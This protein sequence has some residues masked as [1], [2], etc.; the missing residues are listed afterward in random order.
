MKASTATARVGCSRTGR[1]R[2]RDRT[3]GGWRG[4]GA[5][6][7]SCRVWRRGGRQV[8]RPGLAV[9]AV[10]GTSRR[11]VGVANV[12]RSKWKGSGVGKEWS[13]RQTQRR[14]RRR[15][16]RVRRRGK[17]A[18]SRRSRLA[19]AAAI[20]WRRCRSGQ[21]SVD[22]CVLLSALHGLPL[23]VRREDVDRRCRRWPSSWSVP[24]AALARGLLLA[25][26]SFRTQ[27]P[28]RLHVITVQLL[29]AG[30]ASE[31]E[32]EMGSGNANNVCSRLGLF[33]S[34]VLWNHASVPC[35]TDH[36]MT[37]RSPRVSVC[38]CWRRPQVRRVVSAGLQSRS[39]ASCEPSLVSRTRQSLQAG[40]L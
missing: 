10:G 7:A 9:T 3:S 20:G 17:A 6:V 21:V 13:I 30:R 40:T 27:S 4:R 35:R 29:C 31:A 11:T 33:A 34:Q 14:A 25:W 26:Q 15:A 32:A 36:A 37:E 1:V 38:L 28:C 8:R 5:R 39:E 16:R 2:R 23:E 18:K 12:P 22:S 19:A 24:S